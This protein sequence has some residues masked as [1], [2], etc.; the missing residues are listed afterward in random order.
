[1]FLGIIA[2]NSRF[3]FDD[4]EKAKGFVILTKEIAENKYHLNAEEDL[5]FDVR[6]VET[7]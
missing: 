7:F 4:E 6:D 5:S 3:K 2:D 1:M